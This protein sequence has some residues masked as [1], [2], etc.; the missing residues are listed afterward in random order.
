VLATA[1][2][3]AYTMK[4]TRASMGEQNVRLTNE[5]EQKGLLLAVVRIRQT[6]GASDQNE[7]H[8]D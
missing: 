1:A 7:Q 8:G 3:G 4:L 2:A 6:G 5:R